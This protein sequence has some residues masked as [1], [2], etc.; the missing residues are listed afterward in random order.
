M[1]IRKQPTNSPLDKLLNGGIECGAVTNIYGPPGSGKTN[2]ALSAALECKSKVLYID[3]EGSFSLERFQQI[4]GDEKKLKNIM[5]IEPHTWQ[6]QCVAIENLD[7]LM[8]RESIGLVIVDSFVA[9]YRLELAQENFQQVNRQLAMQYAIL[10]RIARECKIP[11][12]VTNQ[13][14]SK[15][16]EVELSSRS[17]AKYWSK[18]LI[19]LRKSDR[20]NHRIAVLRKHRSLPPRRPQDRV[21]DHAERLKRSQ[22]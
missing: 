13:V 9:L 7:K 5:L 2:I 4:G 6:E 16:D 11:I 19:E 18:C 20:D 12:L 3:T 17:I 21:R 15:G 10:S 22:I 14:Y 8:Q 1:E